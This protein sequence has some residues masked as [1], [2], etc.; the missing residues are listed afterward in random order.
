MISPLQNLV[1]NL[2]KR[3]PNTLPVQQITQ[4]ELALLQGQQQVVAYVTQFLQVNA[5]EIERDDILR[6]S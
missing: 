5:E 3:Y 2:E 6:D 1:Y 4:E